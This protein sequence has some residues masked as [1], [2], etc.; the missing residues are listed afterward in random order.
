[1]GE[2]VITKVVWECEEC[3]K[4]GDGWETMREHYDGHKP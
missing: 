1:M 2:T 4:V 3:G